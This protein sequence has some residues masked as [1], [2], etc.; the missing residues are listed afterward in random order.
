MLKCGSKH[1]SERRHWENFILRVQL[2]AL[3]STH[4]AAPENQGSSKDF[5]GDLSFSTLLPLDF[6]FTILMLLPSDQQHSAAKFIKSGQQSSRLRFK[7]D[8]KTFWAS[9]LSGRR[10]NDGSFILHNTEYYVVHTYHTYLHNTLRNKPI[11]IEEWSW[12]ME[13]KRILH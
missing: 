7:N 12:Y 11:F 8:I 6:S 9:C 13:Y 5:G 1:Q 2:S 10:W 3:K 4:I